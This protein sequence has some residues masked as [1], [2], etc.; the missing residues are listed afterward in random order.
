MVESPS[1]NRQITSDRYPSGYVVFQPR[2]FSADSRYLVGDVQVAY[3][4]G[5]A[6][7][8]VTFLDLASGVIRG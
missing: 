4:G 7:G 5:D 6:G 1:G 2:S 8:Y 3:T